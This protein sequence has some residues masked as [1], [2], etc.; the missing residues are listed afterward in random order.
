V[1]VVANLADIDLE[2]VVDGDDELD[3]DIFRGLLAEWAVSAGWVVDAGELVGVWGGGHVEEFADQFVE[4]AYG[5]Y[6]F[7]L[8]GFDGDVEDFFGAHDE[9]Y[10]V[11]SH[12][13]MLAEMGSRFARRPHHRIEIWGTR[14]VAG[15]SEVGYPSQRNKHSSNY[16]NFIR[17]FSMAGLTEDQ[18]NIETV[19][20]NARRI[21]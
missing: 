10:D 11:E 9:F 20:L 21:H 7:G 3:P 16:S 15:S 6:L 18:R 19:S 14:F 1:S 12:G 17:Y 8:R 13:E 4:V 2:L 5:A